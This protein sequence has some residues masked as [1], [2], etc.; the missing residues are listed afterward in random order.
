[1]MPKTR[2]PTREELSN[3]EEAQDLIHNAWG[4]LMAA[5]G[6]FKH[7]PELD[8]AAERIYHL[9]H[10]LYHFYDRFRDSGDE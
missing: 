6:L 1:M 3:I 8:N 2:Q 9:D 5:Q 7:Y 4:Y 10:W